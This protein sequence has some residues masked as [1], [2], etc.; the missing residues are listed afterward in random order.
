MSL[1]KEE[2]YDYD[3]AIHPPPEILDKSKKPDSSWKSSVA[4]KPIQRKRNKE[5]LSEEQRAIKEQNKKLKA[6]KPS[7]R[8]LNDALFEQQVFTNTTSTVIRRLFNKLIREDDQNRSY[9]QENF[10]D[11]EENDHIK[12]LQ[13]SLIMH[14]QR[15]IN[16][17][18]E[19]SLN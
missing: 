12:K 6:K 4:K 5:P 9:Q 8:N 18:S 10:E 19:I 13:D 2:T 17:R 14:S 1:V 3:T 16:N 7:K 11:Q 15:V